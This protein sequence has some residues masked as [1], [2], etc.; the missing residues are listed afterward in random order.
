[1]KFVALLLTTTVLT[2]SAFAIDVNCKISV[3]DVKTPDI[4]PISLNENASEDSKVL[5]KLTDGRKV[6]LVSETKTET[7][8][9][10][11]KLSIK[12]DD[13]NSK[14]E[15]ISRIVTGSIKKSLAYEE[16]NSQGNSLVKIKCKSGDEE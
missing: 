3:N 11:M 5:T 15:N 9:K 8:G 6:T 14:G 12:I 16:L 4:S 10:K 2:S 13:R 1:M 7:N